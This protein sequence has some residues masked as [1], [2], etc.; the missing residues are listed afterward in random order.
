MREAIVKLL[1]L[2]INSSLLIV[3]SGGGSLAAADLR[4]GA[5]WH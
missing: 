5:Q 1:D 3:N 4:E 2:K